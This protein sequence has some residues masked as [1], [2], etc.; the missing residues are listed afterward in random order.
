M[1]SKVKDTDTKNRTYYFFNNIIN[2]K[3]FDANDMKINKK[4]FKDI[5]I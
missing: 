1:C 4:S 3:H 5:L 2:T